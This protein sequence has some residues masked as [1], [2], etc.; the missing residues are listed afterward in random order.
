M[1]ICKFS[2]IETARRPAHSAYLYCTVL[3]I[4]SCIRISDFSDADVERGGYYFSFSSV[5]CDSARRYTTQILNGQSWPCGA[6]GQDVSLIN[7]LYSCILILVYSVYLTL[8]GPSV[9]G[10]CQYYAYSY[11]IWVSVEVFE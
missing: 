4:A 7:V 3:Y 9:N 6:R 5:E 10:H 11:S 1:Y 8:G 2:Q